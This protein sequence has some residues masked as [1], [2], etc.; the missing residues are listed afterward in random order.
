MLINPL[1]GK[2]NYNPCYCYW[3]SSSSTQTSG[4]EW[5][6]GGKKLAPR[7]EQIML[8]IF[9][10]PEGLSNEGRML[11]QIAENSI[12]KQFGETFKKI[13]NEKGI[14]DVGKYNL[15][16]EMA[17]TVAPTAAGI[18]PGVWQMALERLSDYMKP[19]G[20]KSKATS[21]GGGIL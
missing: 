16:S 13:S 6:P 10:H 1:T 11:R 9:Q 3:Q 17:E 4:P 2:L 5:L 7:L 19:V 15:I 8:D 14:S 21:G 20:Q 18:A 12:Q